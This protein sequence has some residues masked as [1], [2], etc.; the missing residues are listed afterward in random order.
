MTGGH[1]AI[2]PVLEI[3]HDLQ[4]ENALVLVHHENDTLIH[5]LIWSD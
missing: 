2:Y 1:F 5:Y 3:I 4:S